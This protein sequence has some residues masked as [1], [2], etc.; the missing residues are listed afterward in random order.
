V[1]GRS[2][3]FGAGWLGTQLAERLPGAVLT[4][5]D[6]ADEAGVARELDRVRPDRVVNAAGKTGK[7]NVDALESEPEATY[8]SNVAGPILLASLCRK[9]GVHFTHLGSGCVYSGDN[10]GRGFSE[11]DPPNFAGS[12]YARTKA[13]AEAALEDLGALQLRIRLPVSAA[14][15]P[16]NLLTKLLGYKDVVRV[17]NS[18][19]VLEDFWPAALA[20]VQRGSTGVW[21]VVNDGV[22]YHDELLTLYR[23]RI[24]P[25]HRFRV[26]TPEELAPRLRAGRSNCVLST[27]KLRAAGLGLPPVEESLPR[28]VRSYA[29]ALRVA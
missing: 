20:L 4:R 15:H 9:R 17:A 8:R 7:P 22:E 13:Q 18:V 19:T 23:E 27:A 2:L 6:I 24:D 11:E 5:V 26:I 12:L 25:A 16:R 14:P 21:N 3:V 1:T 29:E 28:L 10:E